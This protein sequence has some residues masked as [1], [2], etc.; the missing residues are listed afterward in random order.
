MGARQMSGPPPPPPGFVL[1]SDGPPP[2][3]SGFQMSARRDQ[4]ELRRG[5]PQSGMSML[6]DQVRQEIFG[7]PER[8][9]AKA[10]G[11]GMQPT[12]ADMAGTAMAAGSFFGG[13]QAAAGAA[14][15]AMRGARGIPGVVGQVGGWVAR[16]PTK[17]GAATGALPGIIHGDLMTAAQGAVMGAAAGR[18]GRG[19]AGEPEPVVSAPKATPPAPK[20]TAP[21][22]APTVPKPDAG[23]AAASAHSDLMAFAKEAAK[24][25]P[26]TGEKI[27]MLLDDAGKPVK[28]LTPDQAGAAARRGEKTTWVRNLWR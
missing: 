12:T 9:E 17:V 1:D 13:P 18:L 28:V 26:K 11:L 2:P 15:T 27:W 25:N 4:S 10:A 21:A 14:A 3:P 5:K 20:V 24:A 7:S 19:R 23:R 22:P 6:W 8:E 16:N